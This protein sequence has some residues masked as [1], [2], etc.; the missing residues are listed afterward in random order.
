MHYVYVVESSARDLTNWIIFKTNI[1]F[2]TFNAP[3]V[4]RWYFIRSFARF[5]MNHFFYIF[6]YD[7]FQ[8][9]CSLFISKINK[10]FFLTEHIKRSPNIRHKRL[11]NASLNWNESKYL[12]D[13]LKRLYEN[14]NVLIIY[15]SFWKKYFLFY[16]T[17]WGLFLSQFLRFHF[18]II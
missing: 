8:S 10:F 11:I 4:R 14:F 1:R 3:A 9:K 2:H 16:F 7:F 18:I 5:F 15:Y 6:K 17:C 12:L 13:I